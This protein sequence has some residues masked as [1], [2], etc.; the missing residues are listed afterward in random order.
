ML[1]IAVL[2]LTK[3]FTQATMVMVSDAPAASAAN[4][5]VRLLPDPPQAP[6]VE[7]QETND[8]SADKLSVTVTFSAALGPLFVTVIV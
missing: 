2:S 6:S 8:V 1:L 5:T 4:V 7:E 3:Q